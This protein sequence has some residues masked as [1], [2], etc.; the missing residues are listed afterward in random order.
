M[1]LLMFWAHSKEVNW[2]SEVM[3]ITETSLYY[4][5]E[6]SKPIVMI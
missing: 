6:I 5:S 1:L 4:E 2:W 3:T